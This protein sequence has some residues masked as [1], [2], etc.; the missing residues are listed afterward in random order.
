MR[1]IRDSAL[2]ITV[3][4]LEKV[5]VNNANEMNKEI[6]LRSGCNAV[7]RVET[8]IANW[9]TDKTKKKKAAYHVA[10]GH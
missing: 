7:Y 8:H 2:G 3:W 6:A 9:R 1:T 4:K 5:S 10:S